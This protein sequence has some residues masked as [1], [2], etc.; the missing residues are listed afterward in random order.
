[1]V[2]SCPDRLSHFSNHSRHWIAACTRSFG[3]F[4]FH[5]CSPSI[6]P[7]CGAGRRDRCS[8]HPIPWAI[9]IDRHHHIVLAADAAAGAVP[10]PAPVGSADTSGAVDPTKPLLS[11]QHCQCLRSH[12]GQRFVH[13]R[14]RRREFVGAVV[15]RLE[16]SFS[17]VLGRPLLAAGARS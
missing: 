10:A 15:L 12:I 4:R 14:F 11:K 7:H 6:P 5:H 17:A 9:R 3:L 8:L 13:A 2:S 16:D 1:M